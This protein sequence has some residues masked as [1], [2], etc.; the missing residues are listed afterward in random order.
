MIK[1]KICPSCKEDKAAEFYNACSRH[2]NGIQS[3]CKA[4]HLIKHKKFRDQNKNKFKTTI[5]VVRKYSSSQEASRAYSLK[6]KYGLTIEIFDL[7]LED[8]DFN[9]KTC[10]IL[11]NNR[12]GIFVDHCHKNNN[13][14]GLLCYSC[15]IALGHLKDN[16][17]TLKNMITYLKN[18]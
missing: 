14:R 9:C 3:Y 16:I 10:G 18:I 13:V 1:H 2:K 8:Q 12:K 17:Q 4:C 15:N 6:S 5:K 11:F 7:M